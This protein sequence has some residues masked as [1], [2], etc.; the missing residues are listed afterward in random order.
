[1]KKIWPFALSLMAV[2]VFLGCSSPITPPTPSEVTA[3]TTILIPNTNTSTNLNT[4]QNEVSRDIPSYEV[5]SDLKYNF[6]YFSTDDSV[7]EEKDNQIFIKPKINQQNDS[8]VKISFFEKNTAVPFL[9]ARDTS[10]LWKYESQNIITK[11]SLSKNHVQ[12]QKK[13]PVSNLN[14]VH[15]YFLRNDGVVADVEYVYGS[16]NQKELEQA[17]SYFSFFDDWVTYTD[18][19]YGFSLKHPE[20]WEVNIEKDI[21]WPELTL[22]FPKS[23]EISKY[24]K[25]MPA[26]EYLYPSILIYVTPK[27]FDETKKALEDSDIIVEGKSLSAIENVENIV[28]NKVA[29]KKASEASSIGI[30]SQIYYFP[31]SQSKNGLWINYRERS[32]GKEKVLEKIISSLKIK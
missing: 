7:I 3:S 23:I 31:L 16:S 15:H 8:S 2:F 1:M 26:T 27:N 4:N 21:H 30:G 17:I 19:E 11:V 6:I 12:F 29:G 25:N 20:G 22:R 32:D 5:N 13:D 24:E 10:Y 18:K 14:I 9:H 28:I